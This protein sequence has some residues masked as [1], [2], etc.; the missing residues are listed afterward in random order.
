MF[1]PRFASCKK[2][3]TKAAKAFDV[4]KAFHTDREHGATAVKVGSDGVT[5][6][7]H[8]SPILWRKPDGSVWFTLAGWNTVTTRERLKPHVRVSN[9]KGVPHVN[10]N[11]IRADVW[12][13]V[14]SK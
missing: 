5:M 12:Y 11:E 14:P 7:L 13:E 4:G 9:V 2:I 10:G 1:D 8:G 6:T 3:T